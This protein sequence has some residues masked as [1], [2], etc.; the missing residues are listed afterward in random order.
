MSVDDDVVL[1]KDIDGCESCPLYKHDCIG[2]WTSDGNGNPIE[3]PCTSW[4]DEDEIY[5]G[6]YENYAYEPSE[7]ELKWEREELARKEKEQKQKRRIENEEEARRKLEESTR[8]G[9]AKIRE[10]NELCYKWYCPHCHRWFNAWHESCHD[11]IVETSCNY[12]GERL[13]HSFLLD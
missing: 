6:M 5:E 2:G 9:N 11:G 7:Q 3:P 13:A 4:N 12:C 10:G 8:Y 1:A